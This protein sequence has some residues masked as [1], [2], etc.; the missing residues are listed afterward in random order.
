[1]LRLLVLAGAAL[2]EDAADDGADDDA[3]AV[4]AADEDGAAVLELPPQAARVRARPAAAA[5]AHVFL[6]TDVL[7]T[8]GGASSDL[9]DD[10][11]LLVGCR[12][13]Q[14]PEGGRARVDHEH[15]PAV[16]PALLEVSRVTHGSQC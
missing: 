11:R 12:A 6:N 7:P 1:M 2:L 10:H 4:S 13:A 3:L 14:R 16:P 15:S 5:I 8:Q 9:I